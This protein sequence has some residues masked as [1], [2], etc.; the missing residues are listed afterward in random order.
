MMTMARGIVAVLALGLASSSSAEYVKKLNGTNSDS[1]GKEWNCPKD[2]Y[3]VCGVDAG[4]KTTKSF[5]NRCVM[6]CHG[7]TLK[8]K[9]LCYDDLKAKHAVCGKHDNNRVG[10]GGV[11]GCQY[12]PD[13]S[14]GTFGDGFAAG[15]VLPGANSDLL[16]CWDLQPEQGETLAVFKDRCA[17]VGKKD[18]EAQKCSARC[19]KTIDD[20]KPCA[21]DFKLEGGGAGDA[22]MYCEAKQTCTADLDTKLKCEGAGDGETCEFLA[23]TGGAASG[24]GE[25]LCQVKVAGAGGAP[26]AGGGYGDD[27][28]SGGCFGFFATGGDGKNDKKQT[29]G[30]YCVSVKDDNG[31]KLCEYKNV[32]FGFDDSNNEIYEMDCVTYSECMGKDFDACTSSKCER[33]GTKEDFVGCFPK[34]LSETDAGVSCYT[35]S[36]ASNCKAQ[37]NSD[38]KAACVFSEQKDDMCVNKL[39]SNLKYNPEAGSEKCD[40]TYEF[41]KDFLSSTCDDICTAQGQDATK[42][43]SAGCCYNKGMQ[44]CMPKVNK[45]CEET[46]AGDS[47]Y[48][49]G[50]GP[51]TGDEDGGSAG[52]AGCAGLFDDEKK[53]AAD[54]KC[55]WKSDKMM[56]MCA[57]EGVQ[58]GTIVAGECMMIP[59]AAGCEAADGCEP[60]FDILGYC[61]SNNPCDGV[62]VQEKCPADKGCTWQ[63]QGDYG[64]CQTSS[65]IETDAINGTCKFDSFRVVD[66][67]DDTF[68]VDAF[69]NETSS[70]YDQDFVD[71]GN[72]LYDGTGCASAS[73]DVKCQAIKDESGYSRC[74]YVDENSEGDAALA[75]FEKHPGTKQDGGDDCELMAFS[76]DNCDRACQSKSCNSNAGCKWRSF[77]NV[78]STGGGGKICRTIELSEMEACAR[79]SDS[80]TCDDITGC[81]FEEKQQAGVMTDGTTLANENSGSGAFTA[82]EESLGIFALCQRG[83]E[84]KAKCEGIKKDDKEVCAFTTFKGQGY[85]QIEE[86][87]FQGTGGDAGGS[88]DNGVGDKLPDCFT[89]MDEDECTKLGAPCEFKSAT[90]YSCDVKPHVC[91]TLQ[92][93][94]CLGNDE[95]T[96]HSPNK[97]TCTEPQF[98]DPMNLSD[99][100]KKT[101]LFCSCDPSVTSSLAFDKDACEAKGCAFFAASPD[102]AAG[103][104]PGDLPGT[105]GDSQLVCTAKIAGDSSFGGVF[106]GG[107]GD[108]DM[109]D[110]CACYKDKDGEQCKAQSANP[111]PGGDPTGGGGDGNAIFGGEQDAF[112]VCAGLTNQ[113][114]CNAKQVS[115]E[116][117]CAWVTQEAQYECAVKAAV[118]CRAITDK[119]KCTGECK[120]S[121]DAQACAAEQTDAFQKQ[122]LICMELAETNDV[123]ALNK[124]KCE[125]DAKCAPAKAGAS[126]AYCTPFDK[127]GVISTAQQC[128]GVNG[129]EFN[130]AIRQCQAQ[131][132]QAC[133]DASC[134]NEVAVS[135]EDAAKTCNTKKLQDGSRACA[136]TTFGDAAGGICVSES[137]DA[138]K[139]CNFTAVYALEMTKGAQ[140]A[141]AATEFCAFSKEAA[142]DGTCQAFDACNP[143]GKTM[144]EDLCDDVKKNGTKICQFITDTIANIDM[145][146]AK[147]TVDGFN[148]LDGVQIDDVTGDLTIDTNGIDKKFAAPCP[149]LFSA[150]DCNAAVDEKTKEKRCQYADFMCQDYDACRS[151]GANEN[152]RACER[153]GECSFKRDSPDS[154]TG[155]CGKK[156]TLVQGKGGNYTCVPYYGNDQTD[157]PGYG[158]SGDYADFIGGGITTVATTTAAPSGCC[159]TLTTKNGRQS[160]F[161]NQDFTETQCEVGHRAAVENGAYFTT[162]YWTSGECQISSCDNFKPTDAPTTVTLNPDLQPVSA[163]TR[164]FIGLAS[165]RVAAVQSDQTSLLYEV[166]SALD[167]SQNN[168]PNTDA[169]SFSKAHG[170]IVVSFPASAVDRP[171]VQQLKAGVANAKGKPLRADVLVQTVSTTLLR[172][173]ALNTVFG[174]K[175]NTVEIVG[176][177]LSLYAVPAYP[178]VPRAT[179]TTLPVTAKKK[180]TAPPRTKETT[181]S[182]SSSTAEP[183]IHTVNL[184]VKCTYGRKDNNNLCAQGALDTFLKQGDLESRRGDAVAYVTPGSGSIVI[185][186]TDVDYNVLARA[187]KVFEKAAVAQ[188]CFSVMGEKKCIGS[189]DSVQATTLPKTE[190]VKQKK[191]DKPEPTERQPLSTKAPSVDRAEENLAVAKAKVEAAKAANKTATEIAVL[192]KEVESSMKALTEATARAAA[193]KAQKAADEEKVDAAAKADADAKSD[194]AGSSGDDGSGVDGVQV[195]AV[196]IV[197]VAILVAGIIGI[198]MIRKKMEERAFEMGSG[199][200]AYANPTYAAGAAGGGI[201]EAGDGY[202]DVAEGGKKPQNAAPAKKGLVRQESLC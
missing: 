187:E 135:G 102:D 132:T 185:E 167:L 156:P 8:S 70:S 131:F 81:R 22:F 54:D 23:L 9:G 82:G 180:T 85:C 94:A 151:K 101:Q 154:L 113:G 53:C 145:C 127:C 128:D 177:D 186:F 121:E 159:N 26:G 64:W 27:A 58:N 13:A 163:A 149:I 181:Q 95:C 75:C 150:T 146:V 174:R 170:G 129:C 7:F 164:V 74:E 136:Y 194:N 195:G 124:T 119:T 76:E 59:D 61:A 25:S 62:T 109:Y 105:L 137:T 118:D 18:G 172:G 90:I 97:G 169:L 3:E 165:A 188:K 71:S 84:S 191:T 77:N 88:E 37:K 117:A 15:G 14:G 130:S 19:E 115:G 57:D 24:D 32:S 47:G 31:N 96:Y 162:L 192:Q 93:T 179:T 193:A 166:R 35:I 152:E 126:Y 28:P 120:Y 111:A 10:C 33:T 20:G 39:D 68:L 183:E 30:E 2:A 83:Q 143:P 36:D 197:M 107:G 87:F 67:F 63:D 201:D 196:V 202:L 147:A 56:T 1:C 11:A 141:C 140:A 29:K 34:I 173:F 199:M 21:S 142:M 79:H 48:N 153:A 50:D 190:R 168:M 4:G 16:E 110:Q 158:S 17:K 89:A 91:T 198:I 155:T 103:G 92:K 106:G 98:D 116:K 65:L 139:L 72:A 178:T 66:T 80:Y 182:T 6:H 42:C 46:G 52:A 69:S 40:D 73:S 60:K 114:G 51:S 78:T 41:K 86:K 44:F 12:H 175:I 55:A 45:K 99:E 176:D 184:N 160:N 108:T 5:F 157:E 148:D 125:S 189:V 112:A 133:V 123:G 134:C 200:A 171:T 38:G 100:E 43:E 122:D 138:D 144:T 161:C 49:G 104:A